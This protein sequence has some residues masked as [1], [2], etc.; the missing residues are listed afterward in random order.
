MSDNIIT[1]DFDAF[2]CLVAGGAQHLGLLG[3]VQQMLGNRIA[4]KDFTL[5]GECGGYKMTSSILSLVASDD[6]GK[7]SIVEPLNGLG[8]TPEHAIKDFV[9]SVLGPPREIG[10]R[11]HYAAHTPEISPGKR[12]IMMIA[13]LQ[14]QRLTAS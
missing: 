5:V 1:Y 12:V 11:F 14:A 3:F 13:P 2:T 8:D 10:G 7:L 9:L 4:P 6:T